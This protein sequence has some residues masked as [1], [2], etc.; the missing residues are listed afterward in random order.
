[1]YTVLVADDNTNWLMT[2]SEALNKEEEF[3]VVGSAKSGKTALELIE[4][5]HPDIVI[6]DIIMPEF[7]G[8]YIVNHIRNLMAGYCP[9]IYMLSGI[10]SDTVVTMLN[11]MDIDFFSMKPISL[12]LICENLKKILVQKSGKAASA[13]KEPPLTRTQII[14][15]TLK[16]LGLSQN[17]VC[18]KYISLALQYYSE[19]PESFNMLTK[20]LYP[21]LADANQSTPG[22]VEKNIRFA[23]KRVKKEN[24]PLYQKIFRYYGN[25][26]VTNSTFL[27]VCVAY[28][29]SIFE[30]SNVHV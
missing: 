25:K 28:V 7:D 23:I 24:T 26:K 3:E 11:E 6:L 2:L 29:D 17:L 1:M 8:P 13:I 20:I 12:K 15:R 4:R 30:E 22:A 18:T 19:N 10:A 16:D 5:F 21:Y 9:I 14:Q 27:H